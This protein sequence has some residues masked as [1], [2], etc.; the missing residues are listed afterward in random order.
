[1]LEQKISPSTQFFSSSFFFEN[2]MSLRAQQLPSAMTRRNHVGRAP[3][4]LFKAIL[5]L[6]VTG[7]AIQARA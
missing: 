6:L 5:N 4:G 1:V 2:Y 7:Q 3:I